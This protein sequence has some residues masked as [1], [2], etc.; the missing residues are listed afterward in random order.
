MSVP[1]LMARAFTAARSR[2]LVAALTL[3]LPGSLPFAGA[4]DV[5]EVAESS[6]A[7]L[8]SSYK[9]VHQYPV[10]W[11]IRRASLG[12]DGTVYAVSSDGVFAVDQTGQMKWNRH[13]RTVTAGPLIGDDGAIY[14]ANR[15]DLMSIGLDGLLQWET[16][17]ANDSDIQSLVIGPD[18][19]IYVSRDADT[20]AFD[21]N[22]K[23][24]WVH[25]FIGPMMVDNNNT[26]YIGLTEDTQDGVKVWLAAKN[27]DATELW[28]VGLQ[29]NESIEGAPVKSADGTLYIVTKAPGRNSIESYL[30]AVA[31][32]GELLWRFVVPEGIQSSPV[33][34]VDGTIYV[35]GEGY[36]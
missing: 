17:F 8:D 5:A 35:C 27:Q 4:A 32:N 1:H 19:T 30:Y 25:D 36:V 24:L 34:G 2:A 23:A 14:L 3:C 31:E 13:L 10:E 20:L 29:D 33:I 15:L 16:S 6:V 21:K 22:G 9:W 18:E 28:R 7:S 26:L 12:A 11:D